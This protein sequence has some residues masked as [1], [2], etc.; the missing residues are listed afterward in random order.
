ML[1]LCSLGVSTLPVLAEVPNP[2]PAKSSDGE[3]G[4]ERPVARI[5]PTI[6]RERVAVMPATPEKIFPL[7]CPVRE[8]DW[9]PSWRAQLIHSQTGV[10]EENCL[11]ETRSPSDGPTLWMCTRYEPPTRIEYTCFAQRGFILRLKITLEGVP[12]GTRMV[13][14]RSWHAYNA[15]GEAWLK[16]WNGDR[17]E[18]R[19]T[20]LMAELE[21]Y[22]RTGT[23]LNPQ[24][25]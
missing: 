2:P 5:M 22:L 20:V 23:M 18:K 10:A 15:E 24:V 6:V 7:L 8:Y 9:I 3:F 11:F 4:A 21:H 1:L 19:T 14:L 13:W 12:E 25:P 16:Q 17:Y